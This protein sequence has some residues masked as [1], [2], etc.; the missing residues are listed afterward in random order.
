MGA[1]VW[2]VLAFA[3]VGML[4]L[5][6]VVLFRSRNPPFTSKPRQPQPRQMEMPR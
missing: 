1:V 3:A 4:V 5:A 6:A 2:M